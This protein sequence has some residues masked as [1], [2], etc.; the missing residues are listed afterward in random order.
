L[1]GL[2]L[3][4]LPPGLPDEVYSLGPPTAVYPGTRYGP[5]QRIIETLI[6][7]V[8]MVLAAC[9]IV[10]QVGHILG[11]N[12]FRVTGWQIGGLVAIVF[13][14]A[15]IVGMIIDRRKI[16][17]LHTVAVFPD[18]LV[19]ITKQ[20]RWVFFSFRPGQL[21]EKPAAALAFPWDE[22]EAVTRRVQ[23]NQDLDGPK[24][25]HVITIRRRDGTQMRVSGGYSF[26]EPNLVRVLETVERE[27]TAR[28]LPAAVEQYRKTDAVDFGGV[29]VRREGLAVGPHW[30]AWENIEAVLVEEG[31]IKVRPTETRPVEPVTDVAK[32]QNLFVFLGLV[33][34]AVGRPVVLTSLI[35]KPP[36]GTLLP[37]GQFLPRRKVRVALLLA[38]LVAIYGFIFWVGPLLNRLSA[39][40]EGIAF[41]P[42]GRRLATAGSDG[43]VR[44]WDAVTGREL[45]TLAADEES[46][47][48]VAFS[49]DGNRLAAGT[50]EGTVRVWDAR[51]GKELLVLLDLDSAV[52][53]LAFS[54][55]GRL[56]AAGTKEGLIQLWDGA[57]GTRG[58]TLG[59][60]SR[61]VSLAFDAG[62]RL[63]AVS[64]ITVPG[65]GDPPKDLKMWDTT[66]GRGLL[67]IPAGEGGVVF[68]P[69][70]ARLIAGG[71]DLHVWNTQT[72]NLIQT[73]PGDPYPVTAVAL[74]RDGR[75]LA[76]ASTLFAKGRSEGTLKVREFP[77]GKQIFH[78]EGDPVA[79][80]ALNPDGGRVAAVRSDGTV[81]VWET[82]TGRIVLSLSPP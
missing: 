75:R 8:L 47:A 18:R 46:V 9:W 37:M 5:V 59:H 66:T 63:A 39:K 3:T 73:L 50:D 68:T 79:A 77:G 74:C 26:P 62:G 69:D 61:V 35:P 41:S 82:A 54:R 48:S 40:F 19:C 31:K 65:R 52:Q 20:G 17:C 11:A 22:I 32:V 45:L 2:P 7:R 72:G 38:V 29:Q 30:I 67:A 81:T 55:D 16:A 57:T 23:F 4:E 12:R 34:E 60:G 6:L 1:T 43:Q 76:S 53:C 70:G 78:Y 36:A 21:L 71:R 56:L 13:P 24:V 33:Q 80:V 25:Q 27:T 15:V 49:P 64:D 51:N 14:L 58:H 44:I 28:L 10:L 42:D